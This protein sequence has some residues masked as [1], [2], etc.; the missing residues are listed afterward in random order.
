MSNSL[1]CLSLLAL[2]PLPDS[3]S[4]F[5]SI[6]LFSPHHPSFSA[7]GSIQAQVWASAYLA[8][9]RVDPHK[10]LSLI[11]ASVFLSVKEIFSP[12]PPPTVLVGWDGTNT[13]HSPVYLVHSSNTQCMVVILSMPSYIH[14]Y[15]SQITKPFLNCSS[16]PQKG[17]VKL[18][19]SFTQQT[20]CPRKEPEPHDLPLGLTHNTH[21]NMGAHFTKA[22]IIPQNPHEVFSSKAGFAF[23]QWLRGL[24]HWHSATIL[25]NEG[26]L[27]KR[28]QVGN[29]V[30]VQIS[31]FQWNFQGHLPVITKIPKAETEGFSHR[32]WIPAICLLAQG[33]FLHCHCIFSLLCPSL[34]LDTQISCLL[35]QGKDGILASSQARFE[36]QLCLSQVCVHQ[37][38]FPFS[39]PQCPHPQN[40]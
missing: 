3:L 19:E 23:Q 4:L 2:L 7:L 12:L 6:S 24:I 32:S 13:K 21:T 22:A 5:L 31:S 15:I 30:W 18:P 35:Q 26:L 34:S 10:S 36:F 9:H 28:H 27:Q 25:E 20:P 11:W 37:I 39:G 1:Q 8:S 38:L 14:Q 29:V 17:N 16:L 33:L 40:R